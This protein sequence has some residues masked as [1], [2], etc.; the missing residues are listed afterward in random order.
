LISR[1]GE[2]IVLDAGRE[3]RELATGHLGER[4]DTSMAFAEGRIYIR[5]QQHLF[6]IMEPDS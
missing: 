1:K 4:C 5:G 2:L 3:Y 6:C